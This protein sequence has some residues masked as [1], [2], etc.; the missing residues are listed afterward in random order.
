M[1]SRQGPVGIQRVIEGDG[2]P[3]GRV[4]AGVASGGESRCDVTGI[5]G[6]CE[7]GLVAAVAGGGQGCVVVIGVALGAGERGMSAGEREDRGVIE[8]GGSPVGGRVAKCAVGGEAGSY[9]IGVGGCGEICLVAAVA[10]GGQSCV[11]VIHMALRA[12]DGCMG[13]G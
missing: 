8:G 7:I 4:V 13:A 2:G 6:S 5:R 11:V 3:A 12:G 9:V 1:E 10:G